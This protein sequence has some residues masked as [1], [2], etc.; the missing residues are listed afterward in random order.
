MAGEEEVVSHKAHEDPVI[1]A[2]LSVKRE[3]QAGHGELS[4]Q[5]L[6]EDAETRK[7]NSPSTG[8]NV[9]CQFIVLSLLFSW[10]TFTVLTSC[11]NWLQRPQG[12]GLFGLNSSLTSILKLGSCVTRPSIMRSASAPHKRDECLGVV[13][14]GSLS[15]NI[16]HDFIFHIELLSD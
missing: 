1:D 7:I 5:I 9:Y 3:R 14:L 6:T 12:L 8:E 15:S 4:F 13:R 2:P 10:Q 11:P 16:I